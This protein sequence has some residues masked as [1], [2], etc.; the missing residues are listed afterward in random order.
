[1]AMCLQR[2]PLLRHPSAL[3]YLTCAYTGCPHLDTLSI[4]LL[5]V[6][7]G[8]DDIDVD[9]GCGVVVG[10]GCG[11]MMMVMV[12][13][14]MGGM[15]VTTVVASGGAWRRVPMGIGCDSLLYHSQFTLS[16]VLAKKHAPFGVSDDMSRT[17]ISF[18]LESISDDMSMTYIS[19]SITKLTDAN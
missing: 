7:G 4:E 11:A 5:D 9:G 15:E 2:C 16:E 19:F 8:G 6:H 17:Y 18:L 14:R 13:R 12:L 10:A 3:N 1:M